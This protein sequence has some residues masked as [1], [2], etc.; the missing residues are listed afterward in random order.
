MIL[1]YTAVFI[2]INKTFMYNNIVQYVKP[3]SLNRIILPSNQLNV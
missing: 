3:V 1:A 2:G